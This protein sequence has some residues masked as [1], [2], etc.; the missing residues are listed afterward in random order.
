MLDKCERDQRI[1]NGELVVAL[2]SYYETTT[3]YLLGYS[4]IKN[5]VEQLEIT[6]FTLGLSLEA[7]Q[8]LVDVIWRDTSGNNSLLETL[9]NSPILDQSLSAI[10][11]ARGGIA[12]R[13]R[14]LQQ[15]KEQLP[16]QYLAQHLDFADMYLMRALK[17]AEPLLREAIEYDAFKEEVRRHGID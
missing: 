10:R 13:F 16:A 3:D 17:T 2:A 7:T 12:R 5:A 6:A 15:E 1:P 4:P 8:R 14:R 11:E 9:L